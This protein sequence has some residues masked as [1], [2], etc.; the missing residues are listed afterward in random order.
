MAR[1]M[2]TVATDDASDARAMLDFTTLRPMLL[3]ERPIDMAEPGWIVEIKQDGWRLMAQVDG[4]GAELRT[5]GWANATKWFPEVANGLAALK[6][7]PFVFDGELV[8]QDAHG[9]SDFDRLQDRAKRRRHYPGADPVVYCVFDLLVHRG[10]DVSQRPLK[11]R[12]ALLAKLL[13]PPLASILYVGHF[14]GSDGTAVF[15][16]AVLP[17]KLEGLVA[18]REVS[19]YMPGIRSADWVKVKRKGAIPAERFKRASR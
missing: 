16:Q 11:E 14:A 1:R 6:G 10:V 5:R 7:G 17:L 12:K 8:V 9:R 3:D 13:A 4:G 2:L 19:V 18:K 15:E